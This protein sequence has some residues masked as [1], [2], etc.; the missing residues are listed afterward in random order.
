[1]KNTLTG[2]WADVT[3]DVGEA[4]IGDNLEIMVRANVK[5]DIS[6]DRI[7]LKLVGVERVEVNNHSV[8]VRD[9]QGQSRSEHVN[10]DLTETFHEKD[11]T[12]SGGGDLQ[13]G[14]QYEWPAEVLIPGGLPPSF[15]GRYAT[16]E[17]KITAGLDMKGND[18]DSGWQVIQVQ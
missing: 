18:P 9:Q 2:G 17:W 14:V 6:V 8:R 16:I 15:R 12:V 5:E 1:M 13:A 7:Y 3:L 11:I 10:I 4:R